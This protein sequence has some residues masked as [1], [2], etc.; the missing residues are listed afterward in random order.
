MSNQLGQAVV[1]CLWENLCIPQTPQIGGQKSGEV[2]N[3]SPPQGEFLLL[4]DPP[5]GRVEWL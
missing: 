4:S 5:A 2:F 3:R 1:L